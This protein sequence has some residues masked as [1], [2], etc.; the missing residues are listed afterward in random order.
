[1]DKMVEI[2]QHLLEKSWRITTAESCTGGGV[3]QKLTDFAGASAWFDVGYV[4]YSN[5]AKTRLLGVPS[6]L[7]LAHGAVS[8]EI[9]LAMAQGALEKSQSDIAIS[10]TGIAGPTGGVPNKPVG[11]VW[12]ACVTKTGQQVERCVFSGDRKT[13]RR[14][15]VEHVLN[16][17]QSMLK[18][19][20]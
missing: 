12:M 6:S 4:T 16:M 17:T 2:A 7:L 8:A 15:A 11:T 14:Q 1:M 9:A 10:T 19:S 20:G 18:S 13:V 3:A 5:E